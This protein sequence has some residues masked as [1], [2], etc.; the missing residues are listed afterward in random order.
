MKAFAITLGA[1]ILAGLIVMVL[2]DLYSKRNKTSTKN[3]PATP[4]AG[5]A[6]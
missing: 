4:A 1:G 2:A 3:V 5:A 6:K